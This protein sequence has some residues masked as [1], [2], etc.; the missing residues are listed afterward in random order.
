VGWLPSCQSVSHGRGGHEQEQPSVCSW[1]VRFRVCAIHSTTP[2][3]LVRLR[4]NRGPQQPAERSWE[5]R[6]TRRR[7]SAAKL[8]S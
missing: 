6:I 1:R 7:F 3:A 2:T 5:C 8:I 4:G